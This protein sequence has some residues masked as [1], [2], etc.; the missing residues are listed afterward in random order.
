MSEIDRDPVL[1]PVAVARR[2]EAFGVFHARVDGLRRGWG[3]AWRR[4]ASLPREAWWRA[5]LV[6]SL[7]ASA[8]DTALFF[9][10]A[11]AGT[12]LP[13]VTWGLGD[14]GVKVTMA[15]A[16]LIPFRVLMR[17]V[18]TSAPVSGQTTA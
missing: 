13:W 14:F 1:H 16:L 2:A 17:F 6:S 4:A 3:L 15:I 9:S 8:L 18:L 5:P 7:S 12:G 10:I 11:F